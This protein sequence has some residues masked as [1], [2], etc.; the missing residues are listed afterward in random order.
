MIDIVRLPERVFVLG[1][2]KQIGVRN[3]RQANGAT[4]AAATGT[5]AIYDSTG[6]ATLAAVALTMAGTT[7]VTGTYLLTTGAA[8]TITVVGTYRAIY[9][10]TFGTEVQIWEQVIQVVA[11]PF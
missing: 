6:S 4:V 8:Q 9:T 10:I 3:L 5:V 1:E 2:K 7:R 11:N